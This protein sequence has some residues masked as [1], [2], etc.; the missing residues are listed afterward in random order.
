MPKGEEGLPPLVP[1]DLI[2][3][4]R[5]H[6][7][8]DIS[9]PYPVTMPWLQI[10]IVFSC[11]EYVEVGTSGCIITPDDGVFTIY[12]EEVIHSI[13]ADHGFESNQVVAFVYRIGRWKRWWVRQ[14]LSRDT[15][16]AG[17]VHGNPVACSIYHV[18]QGVGGAAWYEE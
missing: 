2:Y 15:H 10:S 12:V 13:H 17:A 6:N 9:A 8:S 4:S 7:L 18:G 1:L 5:R 3:L 14:R 11:R 16:G